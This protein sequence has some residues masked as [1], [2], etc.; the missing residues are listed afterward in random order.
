MNRMMMGVAFVLAGIELASAGPVRCVVDGKTI[1]TDDP[2]RCANADAKAV[3][4]NVSVFPKV[5]SSAKGVVSSMPMATPADASASESLLERIGLSGEDLANGW[6]TIMEAKQRG[7]W[8]APDMPDE[9][10]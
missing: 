4:G 2:S 9:A 5:A 1:Y 3:G 7:S 10:K 6:K 8:K